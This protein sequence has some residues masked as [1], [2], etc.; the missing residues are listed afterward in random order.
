MS[1]PI[2]KHFRNYVSAGFVAAVA[3]VFSFPILTRN[4]TIEEYGLLGLV[5]SSLSVV[6]AL[7]KLGIQHSIIRFFSQ[8]ERDDSEYSVQQL[9]S[10][11]FNT[12]LILAA[13][14]TAVWVLLGN[15]LLP[16]YM[17][18]ELI[19]K[20]FNISC[21]VVVLRILGSGIVNFL[22]AQQSSG[23]VGVATVIHKYAHLVM[24]IIA[25]W[26]DILSAAVVIIFLFVAEIITVLYVGKELW[27][28]FCYSISAFSPKLLR[29]VVL[30]GIPLMALESLSLIL[31]LSDR[32]VIEALLG[33]EK[34]G[35]YSASYNLSTY[36]EVIIISGLVQAVRPM[37]THIWESSGKQETVAFLEKT[38]SMYILIGLPLVLGFSLLAPDILVLLSGDR[39]LPGIVIITLVAFS[40]FLEGAV[41]FLGAGLYINKKTHILLG[42]GIVTALLNVI[43][44]I[45]CV[46]IY[47]MMGA[48]S[49]TIIS[50]L[51]FM[52]GITYYAF[53]LLSFSIS[54]KRL[55]PTSLL[56]LFVYL[57]LNQ[58]HISG[59]LISIFIKGGVATVFFSLIILLDKQIRCY[60]FTW[61]KSSKM[62]GL[63]S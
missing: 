45:I 59:Y 11:T 28:K 40:F 51:V 7:G 31:R 24:I 16:N 56:C 43:L 63:P 5:T 15:Y 41:L 27:P 49:I 37:Y 36:L 8:V 61:L 4:L 26:L 38:F 10:T 54:M 47:G 35:Q 1:F 19:P 32:Y 58:W 23:V 33:V 29:S 2:V 52:L 25:L 44:N 13:L 18:S 9:Y 55:L 53:P 39:Y 17:G 62:R 50:Y 30:F 20:L 48:A 3:G 34:L 46:P 60:V 21:G 42:W 57:I 12:L 14:L 6:V 22:R